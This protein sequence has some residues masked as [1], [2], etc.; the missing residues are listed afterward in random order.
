MPKEKITRRQKN[1]SRLLREKNRL[2][3]DKLKANKRRGRAFCFLILIALL[4]SSFAV[5]VQ[6][7]TEE[8]KKFRFSLP[9]IK[10]YNYDSI[11]ITRV[12]DGDTVEL[13]N[14]ERVRLIGI[15]TPEAWFSS[16][17]ERDAKRTKKDYKTIITMGIAASKFTR[18]LAEKKIVRLEFDAEKKDRYGRLLAYVYL[19]DGRMLNAELVKEGYA[20]VYTFPPNVKYVELFSKMQREARESNR[21]FWNDEFK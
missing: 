1:V 4:V 8:K 6:G 2:R 7:D 11:L 10:R 9:F 17:L 21:G 18:A 12:V 20:Q 3:D 15:D 13:E 5:S 16:K 19:P 14:R